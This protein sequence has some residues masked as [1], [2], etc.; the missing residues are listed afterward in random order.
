M[1]VAV[2]EALHAFRRAPLM[3]AL[4]VATI[5]FSLFALGLFGLVALNLRTALARVEARVE[6]RAFVA[7]GTP[8]AVPQAALAEVRRWPEVA[9]VSYVSSQE[10]LGR[11]RQELGEF[12]DV[13]DAAVLP[14]SLELR[15][16]EGRRDPAAVRAVAERLG[17]LAF[18]DDVRYGEEWVSK[19]Y[20][21]RTV[22]TATGIALGAAFAAAAMIIIG[23]TIRMAVL[24]R[25]REIQLL[26]LVGATDAAVRL[27]F[28]LEGALKG[29]LGGVL[30][31]ALT[32]G[33]HALVSRW[34]VATSFLPG[35]VAALGVLLGA[36]LGLLG[37]A[38][39]VGRHLRLVGQERRRA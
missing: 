15:L 39:S 9:A 38:V 34:I 23:A 5:A 11:A 10:A 36:A 28:L 30:A 18:V 27:P 32:W 25:A 4:G 29:V 33:A 19:L 3:S 26:R 12:R 22:A 6:V 37:S 20:R 1:R 21:L 24:A 14:A 16:R 7:E 13:F 31:L 8:P 2:R 35:L 17:E